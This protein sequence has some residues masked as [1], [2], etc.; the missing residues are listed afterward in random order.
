MNCV[1]REPQCLSFRR[2]RDLPE[3]ERSETDRLLLRL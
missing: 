1:N 2:L 3:V